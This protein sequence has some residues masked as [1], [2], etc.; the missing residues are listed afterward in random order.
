MTL[1]DDKTSHTVK[2]SPSLDEI[3]AWLREE[4]PKKLTKLWHA[5]DQTRK[6]YVGDDVHLRGLIEISNYCCRQCAYCGLRAGNTRLERYRLTEEE[7]M[8]CVQQAVRFGYGTVVLQSGED[9]GIEREWLANIVRRIKT[10]TPLAVT[11]SLGERPDEDLIAWREAGADRY[12]LRFETSDPELYRLIHPAG[13]HRREG[14]RIEILKFLR[15]LGYEIG[16]GVMVG[17]PGQT[18]QSLANDIDTFRA[19]DLDMVGVGP[20]IGHPDT[21]LGAR[22]EIRVVPRENQV[23]NT[24]L[25]TYKVVALTRLVCPQANIPSTT[26]LATLNRALGRELGLQRGANVVMPN[27]TPPQYRVKYEIY[28]AKVC[29]DETADQCHMCMRARIMRIGR[30]VGSGQ[31]GRKRSEPMANNQGKTY[32]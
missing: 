17:I 23:P 16:S 10:E 26:A 29:I 21:P 5:A 28:P 20:Y 25:M 13:P 27:L 15:S 3:E 12:L 6:R 8:G 19:L 24:E 18:Y 7:I 9:Y 11:L 14:N 31:G 1:L 2:I 32:T 30:S 22:V 4:D